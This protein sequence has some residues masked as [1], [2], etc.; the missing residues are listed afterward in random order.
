[1]AKFSVLVACEESQAVCIAFRELG[2][3]AYS[4]DLKKCSGGHPE[5]HIQ[6]D[7]RI[8]IKSRFWDLIIFHPDCTYM[9]VSGNRWYGVGMPGHQRRIDAVDWTLDTWE[10]IKKHSEFSVLEN[11]VSVIFSEPELRNPQY[12]Q[13]WMFGHGETKK[14][15]LKLR[16]LPLLKPTNIVDGR[17]QRIWKMSPGPERKCLRSKTF[18]GVSKA[19]AEQWGSALYVDD[20]R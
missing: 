14:T 13:P 3:E 17:E 9:A 6:C 8:A 18:L 15:G 20:K 1:M 7:C 12:V 4:C 5:W 2:H 16:N 11:P 19:M 10:L